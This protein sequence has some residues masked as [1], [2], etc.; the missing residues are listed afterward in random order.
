M[1]KSLPNTFKKA[2]VIGANGQDGIFLVRHLLARGYEVAGVGRQ[3]GPRENHAV[4]YRYVK[5]DLRKSGALSEPL[6]DFRP[7]L[8]FHVAAVHSSAGGIY[9]PVFDD[10]LRVNVGSL[11]AVLEYLRER[12]ETRLLYASSVK[13]FGSPL[14]SVINE[15]T[16]LRNQCLYSITKN[17]AYHLIEYYRRSHGAL[18]SVAFF[19]NHESEFRLKDFF[20]PKVISSLAAAIK[21]Q[22]HI[23]EVNSLDF[24][25]DWGSAEEYM[26]IVVDILDKVP[27]ED[28]V[29][30]TGD[31]I[32]ARDLVRTLFNNYGLDYQAH[33]RERINTQESAKP[34]V[35]SLDKL[36]TYLGKR[37]QINIYEVCKKI[38]ALNY[39]C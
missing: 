39:V 24:Y 28:F 32:Y 34:Y 14:P 31:C 4:R 9:E 17:T 27:G 29:L 33:L 13:V 1:I 12:P 3:D 35:A 22:R 37:P 18:A 7:D 5:S 38:L 30:A 15:R 10:M 16:P 20:I 25:C 23:V 26:D 36:Q 19:S 21:N 8:V 2:L 6:W 11:H